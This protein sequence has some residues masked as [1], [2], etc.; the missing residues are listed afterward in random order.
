M[1]NFRITNVFVVLIA[2][3][4]IGLLGCSQP[5]PKIPT[6]E[7]V[8][9]KWVAIK[10]Q[11]YL[12]GSGQQVGFVIEFFSD[13]TIMLPSGKG[14]WNILPDGRVKIEI[15]GMTMHGSLQQKFLTVTMPDNKGLVVFKKQ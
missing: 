14:S 9:G 3:L 8:I 4:G 11:G 6:S 1:R 10:K 2:L 12:L 15:P 13:K 7:E 5:A